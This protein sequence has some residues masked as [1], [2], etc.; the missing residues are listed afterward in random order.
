MLSSTNRMLTILNILS[1][2][3]FIG[4]SL[5]TGSILFNIIFTLFINPIDAKYF[6]S[7]MDMSYL[8]SYG[9][10]HFATVTLLMALAAAL[11]AYLF[12]LIIKALKALNLVQPFSNEV[13][14][15]ILRIA[16]VALLIGALSWVG[17]GYTSW[18]P[19][20]SVRLPEMHNYLGGAD[21]FLLLGLILFVIAQIFKK[22]IEI[23]SENALTV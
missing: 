12:Y 10:G 14:W 23:Q 22:G 15:Y 4:L 5:F 17:I 20:P 16:Y 6:Q 1:W 8:Y 19:A 18:L 2:I 9:K 21:V 7:D 11:T 13:G 3:V